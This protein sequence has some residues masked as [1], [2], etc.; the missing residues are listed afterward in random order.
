MVVVERAFG[1]E[2]LG[3][4]VLYAAPFPVVVVESAD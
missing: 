4:P 1:A 2:P 3:I